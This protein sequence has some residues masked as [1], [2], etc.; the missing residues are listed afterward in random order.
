MFVYDI[1]KYVPQ[2]LLNDKNGYAMAKA[3][4]AGINYMNTA[5]LNG[6][7]LIYDVDTM[8]EWRLDELA[9]EYNLVYDYTAD[10]DVKR[11]WINNAVSFYQM[12]GTPAGLISYLR[13]KFDSVI[14]EESWQYDG[15]PYHFRLIVDDFWTQET[16]AWA[17]YSVAMVKNVRSV[18]D[19]II[20]NAG[21]SELDIPQ[22]AAAGISGIELEI[23]SQTL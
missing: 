15:D 21:V 18:L 10:I 2:F 13:A 4:E 22:L 5:C 3:I 14:L 9:W 7:K 17:Q 1:T 19:N 12:Y 16:D 20:F 8:P 11:N 23:P 6:T